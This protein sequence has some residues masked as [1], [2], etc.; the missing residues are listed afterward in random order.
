[1]PPNW[2]ASSSNATSTE[3][4]PFFGKESLST[5]APALCRVL[6]THQSVFL[7]STD[8]MIGMGNKEVGALLA[9]VRVCSAPDSTSQPFLLALGSPVV[10]S[11]VSLGG[12]EQLGPYSV[13]CPPN[14][15][16]VGFTTYRS[17]RASTDAGA[18]VDQLTDGSSDT[19]LALDGF[20]ALNLMLVTAA[21]APSASSPWSPLFSLG[22]PVL[23]EGKATRF[24]SG[25]DASAV[26][27]WIHFSALPLPPHHGLPLG[28]VYGL[29]GILCPSS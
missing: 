13:A 10:P 25:T 6:A 3:A 19:L 12:H 2:E 7:S 9:V 15:Y 11:E 21:T 14:N 23:P 1:M 29:F 16:P 18:A 26:G 5:S 8:R 22:A 27:M 17:T 24:V 4:F 28:F 20:Q